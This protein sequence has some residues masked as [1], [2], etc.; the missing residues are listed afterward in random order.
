MK[1]NLKK[2]YFILL[3][4][5]G[6]IVVGTGFGFYTTQPQELLHQTETLEGEPIDLPPVTLEEAFPHVLSPRDTLFAALRKLDVQPQTIQAIVDAAKPVQNLARLQAGTRFQLFHTQGSEHDLIG[7]TFRFS[8][9]EQLGVK[10]VDEQW[11]AEKI[12]ETI[13]TEVVTYSGTVTSTLWESAVAAEMDPHLISE[14]ADIFGWEVDFAREVRVNDR[15]RLTVERKKVRGEHVGWGSILAAEYVNAGES[16]QAALYRPNGDDR[17]YF[18]P[19]GSSL[20]KMFLKSPIRYGRITSRFSMKRFH[21]ILKVNRAHLG[22]DYGAPRGT[23]VRTVGD[24]TVT[25]AKW[26]GGGGKVVK[27]RHNGTYETAYKHLNGFAKGVRAGARVKQGQVIGYV[28]NTGMSTGPHLH[29][30]FYQSGRYVDPLRKKFAAAEPI[31]TSDIEGFRNEAQRA[32]ASLPPWEG[33]Q[34]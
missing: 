20:K 4:L 11:V 2:T 19:D 29:F 30:E 28:G 22:V 1:F 5:T 25:M 15:W 7:I 12:T 32:L 8:A 34:P 18:K 14:L 27:V 17:G 24:G 10:K 21:P 13:D 33:V 23:P 9:V 31:P 6:F 3:L 26:S 16:H